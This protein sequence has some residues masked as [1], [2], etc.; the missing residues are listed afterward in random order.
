MFILN[1]GS[2]EGS[3]NLTISLTPVNDHPTVVRYN[4]CTAQ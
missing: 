2:N 1:D 3:Y 4:T